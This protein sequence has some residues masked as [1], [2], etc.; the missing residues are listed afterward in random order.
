MDERLN[1]LSEALTTKHQSLLSEALSTKYQCLLDHL[2]SFQKAAIA[3]SGGVDSTVLLYAA[4][5]ALG[6][7]VLAVTADSHLFPANELEET[8]QFCEELGVEQV[9]CR[10]E[11]LKIEGFKENPPNRCYLCKMHLFRTFL[12]TAAAHGI[13]VVAEGSNVDDTG[14]YRPGLKAIAELGIKSPLRECGFT[15]S[16][17]RTVAKAMGLAVWDKPSYACLASRF[18]YGEIISEK[19]LDMVDRAEQLLREL[20]FRQSRVRIHGS[21]ARIEIRPEEFP[22]LIEEQCRTRITDAFKKIG[23]S[24]TALD[25]TGYRTGS[26]NEVLSN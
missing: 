3:Y 22:R 7:H 20:G 18:A 9:I 4:K 24:Y 13:T 11:E 17:I 19:G 12:E 25:L 26:M 5:Q 16:D 10:I 23:F 6:E 14:D 2:R 8:R 21:I 15:K 1:V